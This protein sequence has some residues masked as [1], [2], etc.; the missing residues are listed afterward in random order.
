MKCY[1]LLRNNVETGPYDLA[2]I[3]NRQLEPTD[4]VWVEG[5]SHSWRFPAE[6]EELAHMVQHRQPETEP[7]TVKESQKDAPD[8]KK[9]FVALPPQPVSIP[10][11][12]ATPLAEEPALE[13]HIAQPLE[14][15][16]EKLEQHRQQRRFR[17]TARH[18]QNSLLWMA[19]LFASLFAGAFMIKK[20]VDAVGENNGGAMASAALPAKGYGPGSQK[21]AASYRN[22]LT[23]EV[24]P[25]DT[26]TEKPKVV[27]KKVALKRQVTLT[28]SE[29]KKGVFGG[30]NDLE[31]KVRNRSDQHLDK[32]AIEVKYLKPN[33]DVIKTE[34]YSI[35]AV[36]PKSTKNLVIPPSRRGV[37]IKYRITNI[38]AAEEKASTRDI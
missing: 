13:T 11:E 36:A 14:I 6:I 10:M 12:K 30:I 29:F 3:S 27:K 32:V 15:L 20:M 17:F 33:G 37:N 38:K 25:V 24:V 31:L 23:T 1:L 21:E 2:E 5:S 16:K 8:S 22:A 9:V 28:T 4:L 34:N 18:K 35:R 26:T 7:K 19:A